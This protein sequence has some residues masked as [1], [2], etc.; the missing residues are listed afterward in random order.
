MKNILIKATAIVV[1][2]GVTALANYAL[3]Y[4]GQPDAVWLYGVLVEYFA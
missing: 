4:F 1:A 2:G 3:Q